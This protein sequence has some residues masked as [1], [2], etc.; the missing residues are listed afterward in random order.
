MILRNVDGSDVS[1]IGFIRDHPDEYD[2]ITPE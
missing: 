2:L 1:G